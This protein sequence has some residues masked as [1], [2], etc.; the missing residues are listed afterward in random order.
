MEPRM[1][2]RKSFDE[3]FGNAILLNGQIL[4]VINDLTGLSLGDA[5]AVKLFRKGK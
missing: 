5:Q 4:A 1:L 3:W 2:T